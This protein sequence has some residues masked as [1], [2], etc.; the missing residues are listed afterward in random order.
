MREFVITVNDAGQR[1]DR[2]LRKYLCAA[3]LSTIYRTI[4]KD[5]KLNGKRPKEDTVLA[6]G[7]VLQLYLMDEEIDVYTRR[8]KGAHTAKRQFAICY[9]DENILAAAKPYGLLVHGDSTEKKNTL[10][11]QVTD[12]LI[13]TGAY[14]PRL[15]KSF[16]PSPVHRL[17]R[18]TTG[19]VLFGKN[20]AALRALSAMMA[21]KGTGVE[22]YYLAI[23][24]GELKEELVL[25]NS[26]LKDERTNKVRVLPAGDER[27][28]YIK[29]IIRPLESGE[30]FSLCEAQLVTGRSHQIRA[31]LAHA[32]YPIAGDVK[33][34]TPAQARLARQRLGETTQLLHAYR[35]VFMQPEGGLAYLK[36]KEIKAQPPLDFSDIC[37]ELYGKEY[38]D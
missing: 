31:H 27:G 38:R 14:V 18:N 35:L 12:Y 34:C 22:K 1:L 36:G 4:R 2:F 13:E 17:D 15:E 28:K 8:R 32:G 21:D 5:V 29:T 25:E 26:L 24:C 3:P 19:L 33:Y 30:G 7:D 10:A 11:N 6:E 16:R 23:V 9:E 20:A 37:R